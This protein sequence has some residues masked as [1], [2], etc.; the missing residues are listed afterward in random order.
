MRLKHLLAALACVVG[1]LAWAQHVPGGMDMDDAPAEKAATNGGRLVWSKAPEY[2]PEVAPSGFM[3]PRNPQHDPFDVRVT[4]VGDYGQPNPG[5]RSAREQRSIDGRVKANL[6]PQPDEPAQRSS[7]SAIQPLT[8]TEVQGTFCSACLSPPDGCAAVSWSGHVVSSNN[9]HVEFHSEDGTQLY[10]ETTGTFWSA[11]SPTG[12]VYDPKILYN[13]SQNKFILLALHGTSSSLSEL[14]VAFSITNNPQDGFWIYKFDANPGDLSSWWFDYPS[15][16]H[17]AVDFYVSGNMFNNSNNYQS[18]SLFQYEMLDGFVG[19]TI[20]G[21]Y[22]TDVNESDG[23]NA[24]TVKPLQYPFSTYGPGI[25]AVGAGGDNTS[26]N[27]FDVTADLGDSPVLQSFVVDVPDWSGATNASQ[28]GS[29][30]MLDTGGDRVR[31]GFYG[32][33]GKLHLAQTVN[34][35]GTGFAEIRYTIVDVNAGTATTTDF[36]LDNW[37]YAYPWIVPWGTSAGAWDGGAMVGFLRASSSTFPEFRVVHLDGAGNWGGS[38]QLRAGDSPIGLSGTSRW[39]DYIGGAWREGQS[40][41]EVWMYGHFGQ[42]N[43]YGIWLAQVVEDIEGCTDPTACNYDPE[44]TLNQGC[45]YTTCSGCTSSGA[46]NYDAGATIDDG[47][48]TFPGCT[49]SLAC[50]WDPSAGCNDGSCCYGTCVSV[51]MELDGIFG[52]NDMSYT[53]TDN[54]DGTEIISGTNNFLT[55]TQQW[56]MEPGCYTFDIVCEDPTAAWE[57]RFS[58]FF[59]LIG[60]DYTIYEGTG[61][62]SGEFIVGD[63]GETAGCT[64]PF[65][66]NYDATAICD[67]GSCCYQNCLT[68]EMTDS[69]GDGWNG[70]IWEVV[71]PADG[72][73]VTSGTL[74]SGSIGTS[75]ACLEAGCYDFRINTDDGLYVTEV[76]WTISGVDTGAASGD[77]AATTTFTIG[78]GGDDYACTDPAACNYSALAICDDGSCCYTNCATLVKNDSFGDGW[79]GGTLDL[80]DA[81]GN[82]LNS[83]EMLGGSQE[84]ESLCLEDGCYSLVF[85]AGGFPTEVSWTLTMDATGNMVGGGATYNEQFSINGVD[86]CTDP[87]ACNYDAAATC[88]DG[89]CDYGLWYLPNNVGDGPV[90]QACEAPEGYY[91]A[92]QSCIETVIAADPYCVNTNWDNICMRAYNCCLGINGCGD[93]SACNYDIEACWDNTLCTYGGCNDPFACNFDPA[94]GCDDGS[95]TYDCYGCTYADAENYDPTATV[96]DDSCTFAPCS[97]DCPADLNGDGQ[98]GTPD[99]LDLLGAFGVTCP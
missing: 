30:A 53:I 92:V 40:T 88:D 33:N 27:Y 86:G 49:D 90:T 51:D 50:N 98:I 55:D 97:D 17:S 83:F 76:G 94:A 19:G 65:A 75:V 85:N 79:N 68:I 13:A 59:I 16:A 52:G 95:C 32:G 66:C 44:A 36:G 38:V 78:G 24:F 93:A 60:F 35:N 2:L 62:F 73:V 18:T 9:T 57:I 11:N 29:A 63:G 4:R 48:C 81:E 41:P 45:E 37:D 61:N 82:I 43:G 10:S 64:D 6:G 56:C 1:T 7:S 34:R 8:D 84:V 20:S 77:Y 91:L 74:E 31:T 14:Y 25:Y 87:T 39:G 80:L 46:C 96:D 69:F 21:A 99:L 72:S 70:N 67:N 89:S 12:I 71:D 28:S 42:S 26:I 23:D 22:W 3:D 47:S 15:I 54:A 5:E 58:P